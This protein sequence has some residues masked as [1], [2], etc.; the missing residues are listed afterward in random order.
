[1]ALFGEE[2]VGRFIEAS[3][4]VVSIVRGQGVLLLTDNGAEE[5]SHSA[6]FCDNCQEMTYSFDA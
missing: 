1:M 5:D 3:T 4:R 6:T 2:G